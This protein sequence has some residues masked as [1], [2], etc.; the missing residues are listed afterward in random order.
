MASSM[1]IGECIFDEKSGRKAALWSGMTGL[2]G[3]GIY[4]SDV[5]WWVDEASAVINGPAPQAFSSNHAA[6]ALFGFC[7]GSVRFMFQGG[8][9]NVIRYLAG[10]NDG[11]VV[12]LPPQ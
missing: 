12:K 6:G 1:V 3:G 4:I 9:I 2:R 10:R 7:D 11:V 5:M 8:D